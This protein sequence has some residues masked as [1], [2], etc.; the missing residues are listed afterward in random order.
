MEKEQPKMGMDTMYLSREIEKERH[1]QATDTL[2][3]IEKLIEKYNNKEARESLKKEIEK[4]KTENLKLR[5]ELSEY[6]T[7]IDKIQII[8]GDIE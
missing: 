7:I 1:K 4:L 6:K 2:N 8:K 3:E 5:Q